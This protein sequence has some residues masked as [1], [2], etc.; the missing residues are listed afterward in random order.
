MAFTYLILNAIMLVGIGITLLVLKKHL[1]YFRSSS[2]W[3]M[4]LGLLVLT[5]VFDN[6]MITVGVIDYDASKL[7]GGYIG[8]APIEDFFYPIAAA[9]LIPALWHWQTHRVINGE[10]HAIDS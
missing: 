4:L 1:A 8:S 2:W 7:C 5:A 3:L 6:I 10:N 9:L